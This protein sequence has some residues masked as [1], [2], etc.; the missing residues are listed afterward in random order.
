VIGNGAVTLGG[1]SAATNSSFEQD[2]RLD[3]KVFKR[4]PFVIGY[5]GSFRMGQLMRFKL[6]VD[7]QKSS[8]DDYEFMVTVF[9]EAVRQLLK[10]Y[11]VA[12]KKEEVE[13]GGQFLIGYRG[14]LYVMEEDY[15]VG[16][17]AEKY[18]AIG[19][20]SE[21]AKGAMFVQSERLTVR[22][23]IL[24]ALEASARFHAGTSAPFTLVS[25]NGGSK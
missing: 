14:K 24:K 1:D 10:D 6:K 22:K 21:I 16:I 8:M 20:G 18:A 11:G 5:A 17:V 19:G 7:E 23:R 25:M 12:G 2:T 3:A 9:A 4:G 15:N 13:S